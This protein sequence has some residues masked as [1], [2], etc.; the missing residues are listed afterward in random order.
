MLKV[1]PYIGLMIP[2]DV[3]YGLVLPNW[4]TVG[5]RS[6]AEWVAAKLLFGLVGGKSSAFVLHSNC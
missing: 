2:L 6:E 5:L 4:R 3:L 1:L